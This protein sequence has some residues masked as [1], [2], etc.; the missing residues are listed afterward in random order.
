MRY[1]GGKG[2]IAKK[3]SEVI[4][5]RAQPNSGTYWEPFVGGGGMASKIGNHFDVCKYS[6]ASE[7]L[8]QMWAALNEGWEPATPVTVEQY[9]ELRSQPHASAL[10][11]FV[12][13]GCSF[14]GKW[15]G[16][17]ARGGHNADGTARCHSSES[18]RAV[19]KDIQGMRGKGSTTFA[20]MSAMDIQP[21]PGDVVYCDPP[22]AD[23]TGYS[24]A[25]DHELFWLTATRWAESGV[26]V[27]VSEYSA[28]VGWESIW[29]Q[30]LRSS[31]RVGS[32]DRHIAVERL[33]T[34]G[35]V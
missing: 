9:K 4:L 30:P 11:G 16:G 8:I 21:L 2:R 35:S 23:T 19:L 18:R 13:F 3:V 14:G 15:F 17:Y 27:Y 33:F 22:Y 6:D 5:S 1:M 25:F 24:T 10:R 7:D 31:V 20:T 26:H 34:L 28:P 12:G 32:E 29:E